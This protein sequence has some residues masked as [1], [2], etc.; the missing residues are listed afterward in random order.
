M[1]LAVPPTR[2]IA[3]LFFLSCNTIEDMFNDN[4]IDYHRFSKKRH[5]VYMD[6]INSYPV[7]IDDLKRLLTQ[8]N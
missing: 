6:T 8:N 1:Y 4:Y 7:K 5:V 2:E 3:E